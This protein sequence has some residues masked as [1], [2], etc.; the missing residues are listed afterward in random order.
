MGPCFEMTN[1]QIKDQVLF[2]TFAFSSPSSVLLALCRDPVNL[3][4]QSWQE[5]WLPLPG[6]AYKTNGKEQ[7]N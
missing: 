3:S 6:A 7:E 2:L 5:S 1:N 4:C